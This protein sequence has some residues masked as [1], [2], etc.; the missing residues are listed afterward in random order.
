MLI[1][2]VDDANTTKVA[3]RRQKKLKKGVSFDNLRTVNTR[4]LHTVIDLMSK[5]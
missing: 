3:R 5:L 4:H 2:S 1:G